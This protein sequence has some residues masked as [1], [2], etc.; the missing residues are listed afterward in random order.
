MKQQELEDRYNK[1]IKYRT[2]H[3]A[4]RYA[5]LATPEQI[6]AW[7]LINGNCV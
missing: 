2:E 3:G 1:L 4:Y 7:K 5:K 6:E